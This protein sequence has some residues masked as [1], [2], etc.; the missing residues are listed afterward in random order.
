MDACTDYRQKTLTAGEQ[1]E[2]ML[3]DEVPGSDFRLDTDERTPGKM[4]LIYLFR[5]RHEGQRL[6][7]AFPLAYSIDFYLDIPTCRPQY[8]EN[9][10]FV[11]STLL[12]AC[13]V[14]NGWYPPSAAPL[15][16]PCYDN[17]V[18]AS[19]FKRY[20]MNHYRF[21]K[22]ELAKVGTY[23]CNITE[24]R[25][26][27]EVSFS[28]STMKNPPVNLSLRYF[29]SSL[30]GYGDVNYMLYT[31]KNYIKKKLRQQHIKKQLSLNMHVQE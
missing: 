3:R 8:E 11:H 21:I 19:F 15:H 28:K 30:R 5:K 23:V 26:G 24:M 7:P 16:I 17:R 25:L 9:M 31:M 27:Y 13:F 29:L 4:V 12:E 22:S 6:Y 2:K 18:E 14:L 20:A 1:L 10:Q